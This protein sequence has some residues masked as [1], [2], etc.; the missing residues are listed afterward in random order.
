MSDER[1]T[2]TDLIASI[3]DHCSQI[4]KVCGKIN[5]KT[6][7]QEIP[8][9]EIL[10]EAQQRL[11][12]I[13]GNSAKT[14]TVQKPARRMRRTIPPQ[15]ERT[16]P[17]TNN[18]YG[19]RTDCSHATC[20]KWTLKAQQKLGVDRT[21]LAKIFGVVYTAVMGWET[22]RSKPMKWRL[23][24]LRKMATTG[25]IPADLRDAERHRVKKVRA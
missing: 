15:G 14:E 1:A 8:S 16:A 21:G 11:A 3:A 5:S 22:G 7:L 2:L 25:K 9:E 10:Q 12:T 18:A 13:N 17:V 20:R 6:I 23:Q 19:H 24:A 4:C